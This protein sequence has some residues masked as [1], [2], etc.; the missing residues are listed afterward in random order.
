MMPRMRRGTA[1]LAALA[2]MLG[3]GLTATAGAASLPPIKHV[4]VVVLEN[5]DYEVTFGNDSPAPYLAKTLPS[6]G[7]LLTHY[8]GTGH[9]S[10]DNY[11]TM[12]SG[13]PPN[14][15][16]QADCQIFQDFVGTVRDDGVAVGMGCV[17]PSEV[18]TIADQL[19]TKGLTWKGYMQDMALGE[20]KTCRH[21]ELNQHDETQSATKDDQYATR[22]NPFVYFHS[23]IDRPICATNVVDLNALPGDLASKSSTPSYSFITPDLCADGHDDTC[24]DGSSP[25]GYQGIN[26]F[27]SEWIP[28][29]T[30]SPAYADGGLVIVT[31]D[32]AEDDNSDCCNEPMGPNTPNNAGPSP[33]NGGG[34]IG[35]VLLSPYIQPG[36][37]NDTPYNHYSLLRSTEDLF[38]LPHLANAAQEGLKPFEEDVFNRPGGPPGGSGGPKQQPGK[39]PVVKL[40]HVPRRCVKRS[41]TARVRAKTSR[42]KRVNVML[43]RH[44]VTSKRKKRFKVRVKVKGLKRGSH[45]LTARASDRS[46]R[47]D[48]DT[49]V[50]R[51]CG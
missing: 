27:L 25:G 2:A 3:F 48:R 23:I 29:I 40:T 11:I 50:F 46:G 9:E 31:F 36:S 10:L 28:K 13:Q 22:H 39:A 4:W 49:A 5:K 19:E 32:E 16:T 43:D 8:F 1:I 44:K 34:R 15:I 37:V 20:P 26:A 38:G 12:V 33:G 21:P 18:K 14:P 17:Y 7:Q 51:V 30:G 35:A 41:F 6:Q 24:A 45:L 47:A 42:L